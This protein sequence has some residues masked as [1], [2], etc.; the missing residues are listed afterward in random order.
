MSVKAFLEA[1]VDQL[2][3]H[4]QEKQSDLLSEYV[5]NWTTFLVGVKFIDRVFAYLV[6][7]GVFCPADPHR[8]PTG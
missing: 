7:F 1:H 8:T 6:C 5:S 3:E 2:C 4:M